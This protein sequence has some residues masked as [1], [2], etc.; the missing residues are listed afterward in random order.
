MCSFDSQLESLTLASAIIKA[1]KRNVILRTRKKNLHNNFSSV[2]RRGQLKFARITHPWQLKPATW[3][4]RWKERK[5]AKERF[6]D[7]YV[8][9]TTILYS[10]HLCS[11]NRSLSRGATEKLASQRHFYARDCLFLCVSVIARAR[12]YLGCRATSYLYRGGTR[13]SA[14]HASGTCTF[15]PC[16]MEIVAK[17]RIS[18]Y[19]HGHK[20]FCSIDCIA[21]FAFGA[22]TSRSKRI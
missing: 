15:L 9:T 1:R 5:R 22:I 20:G 16:S 10:S 3:W 7:L 17:I 18:A 2:S 4:L 19:T 8:R 13:A 21:L 12:K 6:C 14:T 11:G